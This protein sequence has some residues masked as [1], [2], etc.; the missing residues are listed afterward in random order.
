MAPITTFAAAFTIGVGI[1]SWQAAQHGRV[2][3]L[4]WL[5][6]AGLLA[7][8]AWAYRLR[9]RPPRASAPFIVMLL[10]MA[11]GG[12]HFS[13]FWNQA[14]I[15][16]QELA[17]SPDI[18]AFG[19]IVVDSGQRLV[20]HA[21]KVCVAGAS[22][23]LPEGDYRFWL[24]FNTDQVMRDT[25]GYYTLQGRYRPTRPATNAGGFDERFFALRRGVVGT[26]YVDEWQR[27]NGAIHETGVQASVSKTKLQR[28]RQMWQEHLTQGISGDAGRLSAAI[29]LGDSS[30]LSDEAA[31]AFRRS[32]LAHLTAV[33]GM[34]VGAV[35]AAVWWLLGGHFG[36]RT[37]VGLFAAG[38]FTLL[39]GARPSAVRAYLAAGAGCIA[40]VFGYTPS[41]W[42]V[43]SAALLVLLVINPALLNDPGLVL[44]FSAMAGILL[45]GRP[46]LP[47]AKTASGLG[48]LRN[49]VLQVLTIGLGA[50][51]GTVIFVVSYFNTFSLLSIP[52]TLVAA[53]L[54]L[55]LLVVSLASCLL[56]T[57]HLLPLAAACLTIAELLAQSLLAVATYIARFPWASVEVGSPSP[58]TIVGWWLCLVGI[59]IYLYNRR[60]PEFWQKIGYQ[61]VRSW[62][63]AGALFLCLTVW[64]SVYSENRLLRITFINVGQGDSILLQ[65]P[66]GRSLLIDAGGRYRVGDA[67]STV[68]SLFRRYGVRELVA[69]LNT[70]AHSDHLGGVAGVLQAGLA[71]TAWDNGLPAST[72]TYT[73]YQQAIMENNVDHRLA[74]Q[75]N[76][77]QL[78][79]VR[80]EVLWPPEEVVQQVTGRVALNDLSV[81]VRVVYGE[82]AVLLM[83]DAPTAVLEQLLAQTPL[84][85]VVLVKVPHQ[86]AL[87]SWHEP[88]YSTTKPLVSVI[89]VGANG[90]GHPNAYVLS[91][92][93]N[94]S[95]LC[96]TDR[97]STI[98]FTTDGRRWYVKGGRGSACRASAH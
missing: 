24:G 15:F 58:I 19:H 40:R 62:C 61:A 12:L 54:A 77:L 28:V 98:R 70:H 4:I 31:E 66:G 16:Q 76:V 13:I 96:R 88:F 60:L 91:E 44:S 86:G 27:W 68:L 63:I 80:I 41:P 39:A 48:K 93:T 47:K 87:N 78:G 34:H 2:E 6:G 74:R 29:T 64:A 71:K 89:S 3:S 35:L 37:W 21:Q 94:R 79:A 92:L 56:Y 10:V 73:E 32:G 7:L 17:Y 42:N 30:L 72:L 36:W 65:A 50:Q 53:P 43:L 9:H 23:C 14:Q 1:A 95:T 85:P 18:Q 97:D 45:I 52:A 33:S 46:L 5:S 81:V 38:A 25:D 82:V 26:L 83:A 22:R 8:V 51:A 49:R 59:S 75:N 67:S 90:Y 11:L 84:Q 20:F 55:A 69:V 57:C